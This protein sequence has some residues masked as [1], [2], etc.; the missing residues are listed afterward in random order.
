MINGIP[1]V[2]DFRFTHSNGTEY[3]AGYDSSDI[4]ALILSKLDEDKWTIVVAYQ[5]VIERASVS[6][7]HSLYQTVNDS[8]AIFLKDVNKVLPE[9]G[10]TIP[11]EADGHLLAV[12]TMV[13]LLKFD[14]GRLSLG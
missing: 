1:E 13:Q 9:E 12:L 7:A 2:H 14:G 8:M 5:G 4:D 3:A 11:P 10:S 6:V